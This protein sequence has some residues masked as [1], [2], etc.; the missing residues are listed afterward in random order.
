[1]IAGTLLAAPASGGPGRADGVCDDEGYQVRAEEDN[2]PSTFYRYDISEN[3]AYEITKFTQTVNG[4]GY[5]EPQKLFYGF[6]RLNNG[7]PYSDRLGRILTITPGGQVTDMGGVRNLK[8]LGLPNY[9]LN[10]VYNGA[11]DSNKYYLRDD[12][13]LYVVDIDPQ[14]PTYLNLLDSKV[15][16]GKGYFGDW[17]WNPVDSKLYGVSTLDP[18]DPRLVS[19]D[20]AT[21]VLTDLGHPAGLTSG[22]QHGSIYGAVFITPDGTM[23]AINNDEDGTERS[24]MFRIQL[25]VVP[26]VATPL[27]TGQVVYHNDGGDCLQAEDFGDAPDSYHTMYA[28]AG[29][30]HQIT[31]PSRP[32]IVLALGDKIDS[33]RDGL[34]GTGADGD[35][36]QP[37]DDEDA[38]TAPLNIPSYAPA[39]LDVPIHNSAKLAGTVAGW[40]DYDRNG[41][42]DAGERAMGPVSGAERE[43]VKLTFTPPPAKRSGAKEADGPSYARF[44]LYPGT[45]ADPLPTGP[46]SGGEV[47]DYAITLL[48]PVVPGG[49]PPGGNPPANPPAD[50]PGNEP[51][52]L[53]VGSGPAPAGDPDPS[54]GGPAAMG[55]DG[56][57]VTGR[58]SAPLLPMGAGFILVGALLLGSTVR[59]S[60]SPLRKMLA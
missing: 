22:D 10:G 43:T 21:G 51:P 54:S 60:R 53:P 44:R 59:R 24:R 38:F 16:Q 15:I 50:P 23:Y 37:P 28:N 45:I 57:P 18:N 30:R 49:N 42:F 12:T 32:E 26:Y 36:N 8:A 55:P 58:R 19:V 40:I 3:I 41:T 7:Q 29:P 14:S 33:E 13:T 5:S 6:S 20:P 52:A 39:T 31:E 11:I 56:L 34:P 46:A 2:S 4:I 47:E 35:D 17:D 48:P 1:M 27:A 25:T 9:A